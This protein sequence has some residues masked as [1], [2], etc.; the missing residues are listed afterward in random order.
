MTRKPK[1][2]RETQRGAGPAE[3]RL[4]QRL[5]AAQEALERIGKGEAPS[6]EE[7]AAAPLLE[8]WCVVTD[9]PFLL[10]Q[11]VVTGHPLLADGALV[12][13]SPLLWISEDRT[14]AR[15]VSRFYRL[16]VPLEAVLARRH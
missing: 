16:G 3:A 4:S 7:L 6:A 15:T 14:A 1:K 10:L 12:G 5:A 13:T 9:G 11:G 2:A 8:F